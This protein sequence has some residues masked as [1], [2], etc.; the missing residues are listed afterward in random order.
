MGKQET[1]RTDTAGKRLAR[2]YEES[3]RALIA[4]GAAILESGLFQVF[5]S[6]AMFYLYPH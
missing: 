1:A 5:C 3:L 2:R 4:R 6:V